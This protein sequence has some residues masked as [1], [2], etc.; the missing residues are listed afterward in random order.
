MHDFGREVMIPQ[1]K[2]LL[3]P[4]PQEIALR[5]IYFKMPSCRQNGVGGSRRE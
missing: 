5:E 2:A 4:N 3:G 1:L